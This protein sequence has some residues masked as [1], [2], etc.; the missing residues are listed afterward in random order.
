MLDGDKKFLKTMHSLGWI[1]DPSFVE[2]E[3]LS[4]KTEVRAKLK[5]NSSK[6]VT[7]CK[8]FSTNITS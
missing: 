8:F 2:M 1:E 6:N 5:E 7:F 4:F 3:Q